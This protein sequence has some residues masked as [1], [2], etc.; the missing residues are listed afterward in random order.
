MRVLLP[1]LL[2]AATAGAQDRVE[3]SA[4][5]RRAVERAKPGRVIS[6][7]PG[8]YTPCRL[9][10]VV[11]TRGKP[12]VIEGGE[13]SGGTCALHLVD[14]R[15]V[16]LRNLTVKG[17]SGNGINIDDGGSF[18]SPAHH[19]VLENVTVLDTGPR[20]NRDGIKLSGV[21]DFAIRRCRVAG[22]GGSAIDMVG[23]HRG[24]VED[25]T[26]EGKA[27]FSQS[28]GV[29]MKG[30]SKDILVHGCFFKDAGHRSVNVG[31]GTGLAYF[32]PQ[33]ARFEAED[34]TVA[35]NRFTGSQAFVAF[36]NA[37]RARV[38]KNTMHRPGKWVLRILQETTHERFPPCRENVFEDNLI[39]L[40]GRVRTLANVGPGTASETFVF[41]RNAWF[42]VDAAAP[43]LALR[44]KGGVYDVDP[45]LADPGTTKM[46]ATSKD[47][48]LRAVG[49][50]AYVRPPR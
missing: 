50:R 45:K 28:N 31:G 42:R 32:R 36:V 23:C 46:R 2:V 7:A 8:E 18:D 3:N 14:C 24:V 25:C 21:D 6:L 47:R 13:F 26:F 29:Q 37:R 39:V 40:D 19:I 20:G 4:Q 15:Y 27:G 17:C 48:R 22:W 12:I 41:R 16:T 44:E 35:G 11:G 30:G 49:A 33:D 34:I 9:V 10:G 1:A 5:L 38:L 43:R